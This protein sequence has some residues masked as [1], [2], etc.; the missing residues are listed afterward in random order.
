M[1]LPLE[2]HD[3]GV[4]LHRLSHKLGLIKVKKRKV[5]PITGHEGHCGG[6]VDRGGWLTPSPGRF[7]SGKETRYPLYRWMGGPRSRYGRVREI[8]PRPKFEPRTV[9][10]VASRYT[11]WAIPA[12][13]QSHKQCSLLQVVQQHITGDMRGALLTKMRK[14]SFCM[15]LVLANE[16]RP[17]NFTVVIPKDYGLDI[18]LLVE[19]IRSFRS[20]GVFWTNQEQVKWR[21]QLVVLAKIAVIR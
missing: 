3:V 4:P 18:I 6:A 11:D 8:S 5:L 2:P 19:F 13:V 21:Y 1:Q 20:M 7:T 17:K 10:P 9:Q 15:P 12:A 14:L 16:I